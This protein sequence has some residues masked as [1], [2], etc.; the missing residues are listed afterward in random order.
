MS[1]DTIKRNGEGTVDR[2]G[3]GD[4]VSR[5]LVSRVV[6]G[7][8]MPDGGWGFSGDIISEAEVA[9]IEYKREKLAKILG[10]RS[11]PLDCEVVWDTHVPYAG[12]GPEPHFEGP[13]YSGHVVY[14][15]DNSRP[16]EDRMVPSI[17]W[18]KTVIEATRPV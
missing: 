6:R 3:H 8:T 5:H 7:D 17:R 13:S 12:E 18:T 16:P 2:D 10:G 1:I 4:V 14:E 9:W 11:L 15:Q